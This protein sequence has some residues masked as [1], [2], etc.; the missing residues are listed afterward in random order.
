[1]SSQIQG[2]VPEVPLASPPPASPPP[3]SPEPGSPQPVVL[4]VVSDSGRSDWL[5]ETIRSLAS[6]EYENLSAVV[7]HESSQAESSQASTAELRAFLQELLPTTIVSAAV[8]Q[9]GE[10]A[11]SYGR[12]I[13]NVCAAA[14]EADYLLLLRDGL[15]LAPGALSILVAD[16]VGSGAGVVGP[17]LLDRDRHEYIT[18]VGGT[19]DR[20][21]VLTPAAAPGEL[22][23]SQHDSARDA[24]VAPAGVML[25]RTDTFLRLRGFDPVMDASGVHIDLCWRVQML[26]QR[27]RVVPDAIGYQ[28]LDV[29]G[30][31]KRPNLSAPTKVASRRSIHS[32]RIRTVS[33]CYGWVHLVPAIFIAAVVGLIEFAYS[34]ARGRFAHA[35]DIAGAWLWNL[36]HT[37]SLLQQRH[38][39]QKQ[40]RLRDA[41]LRQRHTVSSRRLEDWTRSWLSSAGALTESALA[42]GGFL[43]PDSLQ[44]AKT[45]LVVW[46][47][48]LAV[49][50]FGSRHLITRGVPSFGQFA[51]F[52][53]ARLLFEG[54]WGGWREV[55]AGAAGIGSTAMGLL[56]AGSLLLVGAVGL[57]R[58]LLIIG[59]LPIGLWGIWSLCGV[60]GFA[61]SRVLAVVLYAFNPVPFGALAVGAWDVLLLYATLPFML[62]A[63]IGLADRSMNQAT[64][65]QATG[66][67]SFAPDVA[68]VAP[69]AVQNPSEIRRR[70]RLARLARLSLLLGVVAAFEP[71]VL[72]L[73]PL[74]ALALV[75]PGLIHRRFTY[76]ICIAIWALV[77]TAVAGL[78]NLLWILEFGSLTEFFSAAFS[79]PAIIEPHGLADLFRFEIGVT[80]VGWLG[81]G[82]LLTTVVAVLVAVGRNV[83]W[84]FSGLAL[85][86][87]GFAIAWSAEHGWIDS[88]LDVF[89]DL[90]LD[91]SVTTA[92]S[93]GRLALVIAVVGCC[94]TVAV[95]TVGLKPQPAQQSASRSSASR[96]GAGGPGA[97]GTSRRVQ[98]IALMLVSVGVA[99]AVLPSLLATRS[100]DWGVAQFDLE[101]PLSAIDDR[102]IG[103]SY[104]VLWVGQP[105]VL[106]LAGRPLVSS[107]SEQAADLVVADPVA[108]G[109]VVP[110]L[111]VPGPVA[112][113][114]V[115]GPAYAGLHA[116]TSVRGY[117]DVRSFWPGPSTA[118]E[119]RLLEAVRLGLSGETLR[120]GRLLGAFGIR[121]VVV[122]DRSAPSYTQGWDRPTPAV[123]INALESQIDLLSVATDTSVHVF[124]NEAWWSSRAQFEPPIKPQQA[125]SQLELIVSDLT[126]G[127]GVLTDNQLVADQRG[128]I[129]AGQVVVAESFDSNW[130]LVTS[131]GSV[132]PVPALGW[133][134]SF[135]SPVDGFAQLRYDRPPEVTDA[136]LTQVLIWGLL[137]WLGMGQPLPLPA[138]SGSGRSGPEQ[139]VSRAGK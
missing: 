3:A 126:R 77:A 139:Q 78:A 122:V 43:S 44:R 131:A 83:F 32:H 18:D 129:G 98:G 33:K 120:L 80:Q 27:V 85:A 26:A 104:R 125:T 36:R 47:I 4:A 121:Y 103:P 123:A 119:E 89:F 65:S 117:P 93:L 46:P 113:G 116:A 15:V 54:F 34:L 127:V 90:K 23:Q 92:A 22:D 56:S 102:E 41:K 135:A 132:A 28:P 69:K 97:G 10:P 67:G 63:L 39:T 70:K 45:A 51:D 111:V 62:R 79:D 1:M 109:L 75:L 24:F 128:Q 115:A 8:D 66:S 31:A 95:G 137:L 96:S 114:L 87:L 82:L 35:N 81:W 118:A 6:Q 12:A 59:L 130:R 9:N 38:H 91:D 134:M 30:P 76:S 106:P 2:V 5:D 100:G 110:D 29:A 68:D 58:H 57:L 37:P 53:S 52:A 71:L 124:L 108:A 11:R 19:V 136:V 55:G 88:A 49:L 7:L 133:A 94:W 21:G 101:V 13:N 138:R 42:P 40:R 50:V 107:A 84:A 60:V 74:L 73:M 72:V 48:T 14:P 64:G 112:A 20:V 61:K 25:I 16:A 86:A 17:K 105:E 99:T